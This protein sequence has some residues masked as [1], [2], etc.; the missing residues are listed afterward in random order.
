MGSKQP[1]SCVRRMG[2]PP[3]GAQPPYGLR[4][5]HG[6][7]PRCNHHSRGRITAWAATTP[8]HGRI[9]RLPSRE[10]SEKLPRRP[11]PRAPPTYG[12]WSKFSATVAKRRDWTAGSGTL[13][14]TSSTPAVVTRL[15]SAVGLHR[16]GPPSSRNCVDPPPSLGNSSGRMHVEFGGIGAL[17]GDFKGDRRTP[18]VSNAERAMWKG[19]YPTWDR[20]RG[21]RGARR[22]P[23]SGAPA[24]TTTRLNSPAPTP[25]AG[26]GAENCRL[27]KAPNAFQHPTP[28]R[29]GPATP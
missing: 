10:R 4:P 16:C 8:P 19:P 20:H 29:S 18:R 22:R 7:P 2:C 27:D 14:T 1:M 15:A 28:S 26:G 5:P 11:T 25:T 9:A 23:S 17:S 21:T 13:G 12:P 24:C 6:L 3:H